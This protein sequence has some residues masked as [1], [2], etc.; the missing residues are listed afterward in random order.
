MLTGASYTSPHIGHRSAPSNVLNPG[1]SAGGGKSVGS[2]T[3]AVR[4]GF[5]SMLCVVP[6]VILSSRYSFVI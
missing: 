1:A 4:N 5:V 6:V 2:G 3:S